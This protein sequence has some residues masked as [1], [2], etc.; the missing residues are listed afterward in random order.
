MQKY[1]AQALAIVLVLLVIGSIVGFALY[2]RTARESVRIVDERTS[3]EA[4]EL[5]ETLVGMINASDYA[6]VRGQE[7]LGFLECETESL[8]TSEGCRKANLDLSDLQ[9]FSESLGLEGVDFSSFDFFPEQDSD[10]CTSEIFMRYQSSGDRI[11][12]ERDSVHS[13]FFN[14]VDWDLCQGVEFFME[15]DESSTQGFVLSTFYGELDGEDINYYKGYE[16]SDITGYLY[17]N[18]GDNWQTYN[19]DGISFNPGNSIQGNYSLHEVRFKSIGG[20]SILTL[21]D[22]DGSCDLSESLIVEVGSTCGGKYIG[23][24]FLVLGDI[25]APSIFDYVFFSGDGDLKIDSI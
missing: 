3:T 22:V 21:G 5:T 24:N 15:G 7:V 20:R 23:K 17:G 2:T 16:H 14:R 12:I 19:G 13:I 25:P 4:N 18:T 6:T 1:S 8:Y 9:E 10:Y 11:E